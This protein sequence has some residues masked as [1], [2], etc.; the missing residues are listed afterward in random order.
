VR[1]DGEDDVLTCKITDPGLA[2]PGNVYTHSLDT[3]QAI[4]ILAKPVTKDDKIVRLFISDG[5]V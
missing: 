5:R 2:V 1:L 4:T 3:K